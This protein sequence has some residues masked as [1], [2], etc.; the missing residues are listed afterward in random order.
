PPSYVSVKLL[1]R[2]PNGAAGLT[3]SRHEAAGTGSRRYRKSAM[4]SPD[5]RL[6]SGFAARRTSADNSEF[7]DTPR[8]AQALIDHE[9]TRDREFLQGAGNETLRRVSEIAPGRQLEIAQPAVS[10]AERRQQA[11]ETHRHMGAG[12]ERQQ[13]Q[14]EM[15]R[16]TVLRGRGDAGHRG[17][18]LFGHDRD[19]VLDLAAAVRREQRRKAA[20]LQVAAEQGANPR[21]GDAKWVAAGCIIRE[22]KDVAEQ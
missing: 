9:A 5:V 17:Q 8:L 19:D 1:C 11:G 12:I 22:H 7:W 3:E 13:Q 4:A 15:R 14:F 10:I 18:R 16:R 2:W 6:A 21:P 20:I